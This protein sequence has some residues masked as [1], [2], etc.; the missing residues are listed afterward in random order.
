MNWN[1]LRCIVMVFFLDVYYCFPSLITNLY[2]CLCTM[3]DFTCSLS[4]S[5]ES[6]STISF[7]MI[8]SHDIWWYMFDH[9]YSQWYPTMLVFLAS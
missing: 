7:S 4:T 2:L 5:I 8:T 9:M 3:I 1:I 6:T